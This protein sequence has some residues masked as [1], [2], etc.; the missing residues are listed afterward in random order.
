[1][2]FFVFVI[3][4]FSPLSL[5]LY[6]PCLSTYLSLS[7]SLSL[8]PAPLS[9]IFSLPSL[10]LFLSFFSRSCLSFHPSQSHPS[11]SHPCRLPLLLPL[12]SPCLSFS[13]P[14]LSFSISVAVSLSLSLPPP[15]SLP[16]FLSPPCLCFSVV[17]SLSLSLSLLSPSLSFSRPILGKNGKHTFFHVQKWGWTPPP[18]IRILADYLIFAYL[19]SAH[20][21]SS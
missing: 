16:I 17:L 5:S 11:Q 2:I 1:M 21:S 19:L 10:S 3:F 8:S 18:P 4:Y 7:L 13:H 6:H 12:M 9:L 15:V 20:K 14:C